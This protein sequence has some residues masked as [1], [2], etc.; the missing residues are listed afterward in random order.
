MGKHPESPKVHKYITEIFEDAGIKKRS[1]RRKLKES[2]DPLN[3]QI[4]YRQSY[5][6][7]FRPMQSQTVYESNPIYSISDINT[8]IHTQSPL[9][10]TNDPKMWRIIEQTI[11]PA[12]PGHFR[13]SV[14]EFVE[15]CNKQYKVIGND[16]Y[17]PYVIPIAYFWRKKTEINT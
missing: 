9:W 15:D 13:M 8:N 12:I 4:E 14:K 3:K 17:K 7:S 6:V 10:Y 5:W 11:F 2:R 1:E 16:P